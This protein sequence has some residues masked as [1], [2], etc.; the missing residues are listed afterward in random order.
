MAQYGG[1]DNCRG[2]KRIERAQRGAE[3]AIGK[4]REGVMNK[5]LSEKCSKRTTKKLH[6]F[7]RM[8]QKWSQ[9]DFFNYIKDLWYKLINFSEAF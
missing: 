6:F 4:K 7:I 3:Q 8:Q 5:T 2:H 9:P 1:D